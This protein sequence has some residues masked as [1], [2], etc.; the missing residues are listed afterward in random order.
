MLAWHTIQC[1]QLKMKG[2][3]KDIKLY[4]MHFVCSFGWLLFSPAYFYLAETFIGFKLY[5]IFNSLVWKGI[6]VFQ[7]ESYTS[8]HKKIYAKNEA[9]KTSQSMKKHVK[10][11][12]LFIYENRHFKT[13][14][15][16]KKHRILNSQY[17][18][19]YNNSILY[20]KF[21]KD[22]GISL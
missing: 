2:F 16:H 12:K 7:C 1:N 14:T 11:T 4:F 3:S 5:W 21:V 20:N 18:R 8:I 19:T 9:L 10:H 6:M 17:Q 13:W 15:I 22:I